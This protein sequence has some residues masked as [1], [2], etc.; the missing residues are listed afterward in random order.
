MRALSVSPPLLFPLITHL[1]SNV[2]NIFSEA[3]CVYWTS[4]FK[5]D[6]VGEFSPSL[7][8]GWMQWYAGCVTLHCFSWPACISCAAVC[9]VFSGRQTCSSC[10]FMVIQ[11][12]RILC[13]WFLQLFSFC[14]ARLLIFVFN[15]VL[16]IHVVWATA[17]YT[18]RNTIRWWFRAWVT[19]GEA[20]LFNI[21]Q[22]SFNCK[23]PKIMNEIKMWL[24]V[25]PQW[26]HMMRWS[27]SCCIYV[28]EAVRKS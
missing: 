25:Q 15:V 22:C 11:P 28:E 9:V 1:L 2:S 24:I 7:W 3:L 14:I 6:C 23:K 12:Y 8:S 10:C 17:T 21:T 26:Q 18:N 5:C 19:L 13:I 20:C 27:E 4:I 16:C